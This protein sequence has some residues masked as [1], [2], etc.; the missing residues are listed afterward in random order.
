MIV[1]AD[2]LVRQ[3]KLADQIH[4]PRLGGHES[5]GALFEHAAL[6]HRS[7]DHAAHARLCVPATVGRMPAFER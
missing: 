1:G 5:V 2:H 7:L 3:A 6:L 4:R